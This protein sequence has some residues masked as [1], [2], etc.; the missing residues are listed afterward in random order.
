MMQLLP[1][2]ARDNP[3]VWNGGLSSA[4]SIHQKSVYR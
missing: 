2:A 1:L 3:A 4:L